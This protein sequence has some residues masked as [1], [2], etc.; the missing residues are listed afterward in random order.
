M[1]ELTTITGIRT[2]TNFPADPVDHTPI[3]AVPVVAPGSRLRQ[4]AQPRRVARQEAAA[5]GLADGEDQQKHGIIAALQTGG[6]APVL[7]L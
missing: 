5:A 4:D 1:G 6:A 3:V 7:V 2:H